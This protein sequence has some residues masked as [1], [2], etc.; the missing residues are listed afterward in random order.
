M[1]AGGRSGVLCTWNW[2]RMFRA[3]APRDPAPIALVLC[4][5]RGFPIA[6]VRQGV[7][8]PSYF[9]PEPGR[10]E[11]A[12][13]CLD[14]DGGGDGRRGGIF[15]A[16][17][18]PAARRRRP[19]GHAMDTVSK[20]DEAVTQLALRSGRRA[21]DDGAGRAVAEVVPRPS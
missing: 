13:R 6:D 17:A 7:P 20:H 8:G 3:G 15:S 5:V 11:T 4:G 2:R 14:P 19:P 10:L 18:V 1:A 9:G 21:A 12:V 16:E